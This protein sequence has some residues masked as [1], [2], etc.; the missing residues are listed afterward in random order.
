M[1][2][3]LFVFGVCLCVAGRLIAQDVHFMKQH[4]EAVMKSSVYA[5]KGMS[6][7]LKT[8]L[9]YDALYVPNLSAELGLGKNMSI[10]LDYWYTWF[11]SNP[12]HNYWRSYGGG[13]G[14]RRYLGEQSY[15]QSLTGHHIG[16]V[17]QMGMYD[18]EYGKRGNMSDF[19]YTLG[20]E[21]GYVFPLSSRFSL[22]LS[23][24]FGYFGG[25]YKVYDPID[26]HYVWKENRNRNYFGPI[27]ADI[28]L[29]Y[30]ISKYRKGDKR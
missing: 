5:S 18:V 25:R 10:G 24:A 26:T 8:N 16:I 14:I 28:T 23:V 3:R 21:Y 13:I 30:Q 6:L 12:T 22:D 17:S 19:F 27:K 9:L 7:K 15:R 4:E 11:D 2:K 29:A 1:K 20:T